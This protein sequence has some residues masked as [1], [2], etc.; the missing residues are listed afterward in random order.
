M[1]AHSHLGPIIERVL[2]NKE[3][4]PHEKAVLNYLTL[5]LKDFR[6][7]TNSDLE[8]HLQDWRRQNATV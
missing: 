5:V 7:E 8:I 4:V 3:L 1:I 2:S 6:I